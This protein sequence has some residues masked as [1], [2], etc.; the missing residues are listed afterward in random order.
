MSRTHVF[1]LAILVSL[2]T[3]VR[4][5]VK[6]KVDAEEGYE[7]H[8]NLVYSKPAGEELLLDAY[9]P[10]GSGP[11]P[12]ILV[13]HGGAWKSGNKFQLSGYARALA[14]RGF[15]AFAI[16]YRLAPK[17]KHPA[18]IE[19][20]RAAVKWIRAH[21]KDYRVDPD[22]LGA[23][24]YSAGAH[25]VTLL[26]T[27]R[28]R[29]SE[30]Q[31]RAVVAGGT[32]IDFRVM[33]PDAKKLVGWLGGTRREIPK[34]YEAVSPYLHVSAD[35][36]PIFF[37][38]GDADELVDIRGAEEMVKALRKVGIP[39]DLH[40][41]KGGNHILAA[42]NPEALEASWRFFEKNLKDAEPGA[43]AR[44][45]APAATAPANSATGSR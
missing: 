8:R 36:P 23:V 19:D 37:F 26:G 34:V 32:P 7:V 44:A 6:A 17:H 29:T 42:M 24:G 40:V 45:A 30:T 43:P 18:Q 3:F 4:A 9:V 22:R 20:C 11:L 12:A 35:D 33:D 25:L 5:E 16:N 1:A 28:D 13:V 27:E 15:A 10:D 41:I 31:V 14:Q 21:A 38:H 39:A 2:P